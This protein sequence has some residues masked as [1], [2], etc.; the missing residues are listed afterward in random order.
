MRLIA[1]DRIQRLDNFDV[2]VFE[3]NLQGDHNLG[4]AKLA[5]DLFGAIVGKNEGPQG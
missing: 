1:P 4:N 2:F 5:R 3:S